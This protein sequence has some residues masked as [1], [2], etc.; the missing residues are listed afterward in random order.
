MQ[1]ID[2]DVHWYEQTFRE[3]TMELQ[4]IQNG[5]TPMKP[6]EE[7][8]EKAM[9]CCKS[10]DDPEQASKKQRRHAQDKEINDNDNEMDD[11]TPMVPMR[12]TNMVKHLNIPVGEIRLGADDDAPT[13]ATQET[14][15]KNL[16]Y[17][18]NMP[19]GTRETVENVRD[20]S[21]NTSKQDDKKP[22]PVEKTDQVTCNDQLNAYRKS[23][24]DDDPT[25]VKEHRKNTWQMRKIVHMEFESDDD[26]NEQ[27]KKS[28]DVKVERKV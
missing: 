22:S 6:S 20:S 21:K 11:K 3:I 17:I 9:M 26:V 10:L 5:E 14:P 8:N 13:L 7:P 23:D 4:K 19:E 18:T 27:A 2:T 12:T 25:T 28:S 24:R 1:M 16:V 15:V